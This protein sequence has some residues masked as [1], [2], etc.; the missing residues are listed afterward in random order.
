MTPVI[1]DSDPT[2][3]ENKQE[4]AKEL[5]EEGKRKGQDGRKNELKILH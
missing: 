5:E 4:T 2:A 1:N 3:V